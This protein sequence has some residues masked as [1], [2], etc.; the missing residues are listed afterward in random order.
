MRHFAANYIFN[1]SDFVKNACLS[2]GDDG[3]LLSIGVENSGIEEKERMIF[4]NGIICPRFSIE[5]MEGNDLSLRDF[6]VSLGLNFNDSLVLP[7]V[8]LENVDLQ[9]LSFTKDTIAKEIY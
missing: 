3:H 2:F 4:Y 6:L 7:V 1:G 5:L 9:T 8:L